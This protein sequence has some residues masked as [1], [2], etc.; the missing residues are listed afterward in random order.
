MTKKAEGAPISKPHLCTDRASSEHRRGLVH[1]ADSLQNELR[2]I[3]REPD[4][5]ERAKREM[6][7][8]I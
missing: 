2:P 7:C 4:F 5:E 8:F 3:D 1:R 6:P